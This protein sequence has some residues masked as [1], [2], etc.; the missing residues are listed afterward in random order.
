MSIFNSQE[1]ARLAEALRNGEGRLPSEEEVVA[2]VKW[3]EGVVLDSTVLDGVL[4]GGF[5][6][7][8]RDGQWA[9]KVTGYDPARMR[10]E[11]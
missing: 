11:D 5:D 3:A 8:W 1:L 4:S 9:F 10:D 7:S 2:L 6:V